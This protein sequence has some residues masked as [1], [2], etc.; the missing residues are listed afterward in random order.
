MGIYGVA[1]YGVDKYGEAPRLAFS[2]A[3]FLSSALDYN[4]VSLSWTQPEGDYTALRLLR[5]QD[6]YS[7]TEEDGVVLWEWNESSGE[8]RITSFVDTPAEVSSPLTS[9]R[10]AYYTIW[11]LKDT[12]TWTLTGTTFT[13]V[14][15]S[16]AAVSPDGTTLVSTHERLMDYL[17]RT[18]TSVTQSPLDVVDLDSELS[19][20]LSAMSF[21][22]DELLTLA[23]NLLPDESGRF[24][25]PQLVDLGSLELGFV[26]DPYLPVKNKKRLIREGINIFSYKGTANAVSSY[27][28]SLTG[29]APLTKV[30]S[31]LMLSL[32]DSTFYK[33][34]GFWYPTGDCTLTV[35]PSV[36]VITS[37]IE[38]NSMDTQYSGKVVVTTAGAGIANGNYNPTTRG[39]P[40]AFG[41]TYTFS[42][43][44]QSVSGT[45][46]I[47]P[48]ISWFDFEGKLI[49]TNTAAS[50]SNAGST[51]SKQSFTAKAPGESYDVS[52]YEVVDDE[53]TLTTS[54]P[55]LLLVGSSIQVIGVD[56]EV[57]GLYTVTASTST[58]V[59]YEL[60]ANTPALNVSSTEV[61][62]ATVSPDANP[63]VYASVALTFGT[64]GTV[65][66][67]AMQFSLSSVTAYDEAR[68]VNIFLLPTKTNYLSNPSF[69][70]GNSSEWSVDAASFSYEDT[71]L[72]LVLSGDDMLTLVS[73]AGA[74]TSISAITPAITSGKYYTFSIYAK[75]LGLS[76][77]AASVSSGVATLT[78][79]ASPA[80]SVGDTIAVNDVSVSLDGE[81]VI[82]AISGNQV[83]YAVDIPDQTITVTA[84]SRVCRPETMNLKLEAYDEVEEAVTNVRVSDGFSFTDD[85]ARYSVTLFVE[86]NSNDTHLIATV[87]G[88]TA[89]CSMSFDAAQVEETYLATDYFD[90]SYPLTYG[91]VWE[92]TA[93]DSSSHAYPNKDTK[94]IRL[95]DSLS[96]YLP[97]NTAFRIETYAGVE[98]AVLP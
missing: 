61:T 23:D 81:N 6:G 78:M 51:W 70:S 72:E 4:S 93:N 26:N 68:A 56:G 67:D 2:V 18:F 13:V 74:E 87:V 92:G 20:F 25:G 83:S 24:L 57:D 79:S 3:P 96:E 82:T 5:S 7:E 54:G 31:N 22:L 43:Y 58:T 8:P 89:G 53:V 84:E 39:V 38:P 75:M 32:A 76:V 12:G 14:P 95:K 71:T 50:S 62:D 69:D 88:N 63:A 47:T 97:L 33:G 37:A 19:K 9:G 59:T 77:T 55:H 34:I 21:T 86:L 66:L 15:A 10:F 17:P 60:E 45:M 73:N 35:E 98:H 30:S 80:W 36:P 28:E 42:Y 85:W 91:A 11:A 41:E 40:I 16:H 48:S 94:L 27:A 49:T 65:Y 1:T 90:G 64:T 44:A 46:A 52:S 29:F